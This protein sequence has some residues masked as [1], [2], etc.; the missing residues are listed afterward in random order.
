MDIIVG[1]VLS[2]VENAS[3]KELVWISEYLTFNTDSSNFVRH[4]YGYDTSLKLFHKIQHVF[5]TGLISSVHREGLKQNF[6]IEVNDFR[7]KPTEEDLEV[8]ISYLRDYQLEAVRRAIEVGRGILKIGTGGG[9]SVIGTALV[10]M[11]PCHWLFIVNSKDL[12][13][14]MADKFTQFTGELTGKIGDGLWSPDKNERLT[15]ATFQ[16][17]HRMWSKDRDKA[18]EFLNSIEGLIVDEAHVLAAD[19]FLDLAMRLSNA[20]YRIGLSATPLDRGDKKS[21]CTIAALGPVIY[22]LKAKDLIERG[23]LAEPKIRM[24]QLEQHS[25]KATHQ[26]VYSELIVRSTSRNKKV[27]EAAQM[28]EKPCLLFVKQVNHGKELQ[29]RLLKAGV[30]CDFTW[31]EKDTAHRKECVK[32][33]LRAEIDVLIVSVIFN[34]G[35][36][37]PELRSVV[38]ASAGKSVIATLQRIGRGMRIT[39]EKR[40]FEVYDVL[41]TG[42]KWMSRHAEQRRRAYEREGF[43][44]EIV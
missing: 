27:V 26:G 22:E 9:K 13:H 18:K 11:I 5:P 39:D 34:V 41:D 12:M 8:D 4:K 43:N 40:T 21:I 16:T 15:V 23:V 42:N 30:N 35:I 37:I 44:V 33:L 3:P 20:Y 25:L 31:G 7:P 6:T 19:S 28:A 32:K 24:L 29:K 36:D 17:I 14:Q 1:N 2:K 10:Q 38:V